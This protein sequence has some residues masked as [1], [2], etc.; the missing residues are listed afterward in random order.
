MLTRTIR[1]QIAA[2][3]VIALLGV[4][5]V[6]VRYAGL[7]R[8]IGD[9]GYKVTLSLPDSG[10]IFTNAEVTYRGVPVGRVGAMRLTATGIS[11]DLDITSSRHIPASAHAVVADRSVVGEQF[12]DLRP[13]TDSGP[14]LHNGSHL[15]SGASSLP[16]PIENLLVSGDQLVQSVPIADLQTVVNEIYAATQNTGAD[17][18]TLLDT[19]RK[20][21][22]AATA[23][24]PKTI[25]LITVAKTVLATQANEADSIASFSHNLALI[26][27]QLKSSDGDVRRVLAGAVPAA[28]QISGLIKG[29]GGSLSALLSSL[30]TTSTVVLKH[31]D[32]LREL[33]VQLPV[34]V[35]IGGSIV[36]PQGINVGLVPT[37]FDPLPC[38]AG[39]GSTVK[40]TGQDT[41]ATPLNTSAGCTASASTGT[42]VRGSQHAPNG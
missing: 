20:F 40:H 36:T 34:V 4:S 19:S 42:D 10:G 18:Q 30:L 37:F 25:D 9:S 1:A 33:L 8:L 27:N 21:F 28:Q 38:T 7:Q 35:S 12:V 16:P 32:A 17:L 41:T 3:L 14:Y 23:D 5:Y 2:F 24:L 15:A 39:Y 29:I 31:K 22:A 11:V 6:G 26:G 13:T